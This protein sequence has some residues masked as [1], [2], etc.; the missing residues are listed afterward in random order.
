MLEQEFIE[1]ATTEWTAPIVFIA[2]KNG[3][4]QFC[5]DYLT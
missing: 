1:P 2:K 4:L 3:I 5:V